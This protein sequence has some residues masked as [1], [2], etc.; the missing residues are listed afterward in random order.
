MDSR[1]LGDKFRGNDRGRGNDIAFAGMTKS[2]SG[3]AS[4]ALRTEGSWNALGQICSRCNDGVACFA[5]VK[6]VEKLLETAKTGRIALP[7]NFVAPVC[8][9]REGFLWKVMDANG[10]VTA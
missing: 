5:G 1:S 3:G 10:N 9:Q 6:F 8:I 2:G 4:P 7:E